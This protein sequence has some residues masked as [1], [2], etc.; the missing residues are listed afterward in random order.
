MEAKDLIATPVYLL[1]FLVAAYFLRPQV[2]T[3]LTRRYFFPALM[4]KFLGALFLGLIY[5]FYYGGGDTFG[6]TTYGA[7]HI[8]RA[9]LDEPPVAFDM[10]FGTNEYTT[11]NFKYAVKIWY[12]DDAASYFVVRVAGIL[13]LLSFNTYSVIALLFAIISFS[14]LWAFYTALTKWYPKLHLPFAIA[15]FGIPSVVFWGSGVMKDTLTIGALGWAMYALVNLIVFK[16]QLWVSIPILVLAILVIYTIKIY[17]LLCFFPS[18]MIW[19]FFSWLITVKKQGG[20]VIY[21]TIGN[22]HCHKLEL[23]GANANCTRQ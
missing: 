5:Q 19:L 12:F 14:G 17:I 1:I 2:S 16:K 13:S 11:K 20:Q 7:S 23:L 6:Y 4:L 15:I 3:P 22:N 10:I 18:V 21:S 8:W 9:F